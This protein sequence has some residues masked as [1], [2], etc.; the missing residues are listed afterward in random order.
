M[1]GSLTLSNQYS[2]SAVLNDCNQHFTVYVMVTQFN[3]S[4]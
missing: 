2:G 4:L 3:V 1:K